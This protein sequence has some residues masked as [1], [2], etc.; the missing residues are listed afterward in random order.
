MKDKFILKNFL[1]ETLIPLWPIQKGQTRWLNLVTKM[2]QIKPYGFL[3]QKVVG[4]CKLL[5]DPG[6][7]NDLLYYFGMY[8]EAPLHLLRTL[9]RSGDC[10]LDIGAN[11]GLYSAMLGKL[12]GKHGH[13]HALE[14]DPTLFDRLKR[15]ASEVFDGPV[16]VY[17]YGVTRTSGE[18]A[19]FFVSTTSGWSSFK[20]N[21]TFETARGVSVPTI[22]IDEFVMKEGI[23]H[24]RLIKMDIEGGETD[25]ILGS[26]ASLGK[27]LIDL[28]LLEAEPHRMK[29]FGYT[30]LEIA[31]LMK[32][33][34]YEPVALVKDDKIH[35]VSDATRIPGSFNGDYL[36]CRKH[37]SGEV[38]DCI[39]RW[40]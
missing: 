1:Y 10:C 19:L 31:E 40:I 17:H 38:L 34:E 3:K 36:Y 8:G 26:Q 18:N 33:H 37:L 4:Q 32:R 22:T 25:A 24:I 23:S 16:K 5:L 21:D 27:G 35:A 15:S 29:S 2:L 7:K 9:I 14:A 39:G 11:V 13:I 12:V 30:G 28:V 6:D 20:E